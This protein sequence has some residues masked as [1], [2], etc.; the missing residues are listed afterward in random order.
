MTV[1]ASLLFGAF[2]HYPVHRLDLGVPANH[3]RASQ[4]LKPLLAC[5]QHPADAVTVGHG[6][7]TVD[8]G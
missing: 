6:S 2:S 7:H 3:R 5:N 8:I 4:D 1:T